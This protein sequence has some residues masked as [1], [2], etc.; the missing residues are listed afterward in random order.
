MD[1]E[2]IFWS[3]VVLILVGLSLPPA[4]RDRSLKKFF[5]A[6]VLSAIGILIPFFF[7]IMSVFL[8]PDWK[9]GCRFGWL[10][11]FQSGKLA[12]TPLVLWASP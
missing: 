7:F 3:I 11:C 9:G 2:N 5:I 10:D 1:E 4:I 12:L 6:F 8:L